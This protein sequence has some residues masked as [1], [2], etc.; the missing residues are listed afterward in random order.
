MSD[1]AANAATT[2]EVLAPNGTTSSGQE[3][4]HL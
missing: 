2:A 4:L 1:T 3:L